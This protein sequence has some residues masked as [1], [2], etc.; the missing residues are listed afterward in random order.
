MERPLGTV[1]TRA[2]ARLLVIDACQELAGVLG[3]RAGLSEPR[4]VADEIFFLA[5][6]NPRGIDFLDDVTQPVSAALGVIATRGQVILLR[7]KGSEF[8]VCSADGV[9]S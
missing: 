7:A 5:G 6:T 1:K 8:A 3:E 2:G 9:G 4:R